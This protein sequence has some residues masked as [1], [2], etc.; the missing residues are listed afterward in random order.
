MSN[1]RKFFAV[2]FGKAPVEAGDDPLSEEFEAARARLHTAQSD[3]SRVV[4]EVLEQNERLRARDA[5]RRIQNGRP[6]PGR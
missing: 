3:F 6:E 4:R 5:H 1:V 2:L